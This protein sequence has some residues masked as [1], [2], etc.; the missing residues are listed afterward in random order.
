MKT[1]SLLSPFAK[2]GQFSEEELQYINYALFALT[3]EL[4][5][6]LV[7]GILFYF[8]GKLRGF[9]FLC[10]IILPL[11]WFCGGFHC[12]TLIRCFVCSLIWITAL[13][14]LPLLM[15]ANSIDILGLFNLA[16]APLI[17]SRIPYTPPI[18]QIKNPRKI[19]RLRIFAV[20][21]ILLC[22]T[23][24]LC[25]KV[26]HADYSLIGLSALASVQIQLFIPKRKEAKPLCRKSSI[27]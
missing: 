10:I 22:V 17:L 3:N 23:L 11:R 12:K 27:L 9:L 5:K 26:Y 4:S 19:K 1:H 2:S 13:L 16:M 14:Y 24:C 18:R 25:L 21:D 8:L 7:Y 6:T 20:I 15:T